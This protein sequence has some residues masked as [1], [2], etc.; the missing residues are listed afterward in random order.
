[1]ILVT[2]GT[3][4]LGRRL[5]EKLPDVIVFAREE[6]RELNEKGVKVFTGDIKN[7]EELEKAFSGVDIVYHLA[8]NL[9]ESD[10]NMYNDNVIGTRN[11]VELSKKNQIKKIIFM[12]S[13]GALGDSGVAKENSPYNPKTKYEK[14]KAESEKIIKESGITYT[15]VRAPVMLGPNNIWLKI[16][17]AAKQ[18]YPII[19]S[20]KNHF[21]LAYVD[22]VV[23]LLVL[24]KDRGDNQV[25]HIAVT[26]TPTYEEIY[27]MICEEAGFS[28][29]DKHISVWLIKLLS[30]FHTFSRKIRGKKPSLTM[31][32]SSIHRLIR[33][34]VIDMENTK[35]SLDFEPK[36]D[37]RTAI[38]ETVKYFKNRNM[39]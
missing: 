14:S 28:F 33:D 21:H 36:Y 10:S 11:V 35:K 3:G 24:V 17:Q 37:T 34:R 6:D 38:R 4:F 15:V 12:G 9:D 26:D 1:M 19:G 13:C 23:R 2:G 16:M 18:H 20:G 32:K 5:V 8:A 25:F 7:K 27:K 31:M 30:S 29:T 22:D 39:L